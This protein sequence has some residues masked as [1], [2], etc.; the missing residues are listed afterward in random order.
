MPG[1]TPNK[2]LVIWRVF[3]KKNIYSK[4]LSFIP[5][6][7]NINGPGGLCLILFDNEFMSWTTDTQWLDPK[8]CTAHN[9]KN[10][11]LGVRSPSFMAKHYEITEFISLAIC[12]GKSFSEALILAS[13]NPQYDKRLFIELQVHVSTWKLHAQNALRTCCVHKLFW[14]SKQKNN[15]CTQHVLSL[16]FSCTELVNQWTICRHTVG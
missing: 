4:L 7:Y 15:V 8:F 3:F 5:N 11:S 14:M 1:G 6:Y 9:L 10:I 12:T 2:T 13:T 16:K